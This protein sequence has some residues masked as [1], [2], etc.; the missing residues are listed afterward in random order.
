MFIIKGYIIVTTRWRTTT[1]LVFT[2][3]YFTQ[4]TGCIFL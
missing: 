1:K 4:I 3:L 2:Y